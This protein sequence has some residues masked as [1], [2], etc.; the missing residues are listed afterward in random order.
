MKI[1]VILEVKWSIV[2]HVSGTFSGRVLK[3]IVYTG[4]IDF[5]VKGD[6][7]E[8]YMPQTSVPAMETYSTRRFSMEVPGNFGYILEFKWFFYG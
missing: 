5:N 3:K 7:G 8:I 4:L 2:F 6:F 1:C